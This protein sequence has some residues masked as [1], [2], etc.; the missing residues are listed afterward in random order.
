MKNHQTNQILCSTLEFFLEKYTM[1]KKLFGIYTLIF[2]T[3]YL[4]YELI[5]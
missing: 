1:H 4:Y 5:K 2:N 3:C